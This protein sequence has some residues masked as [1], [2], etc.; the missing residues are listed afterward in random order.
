MLFSQDLPRPVRTLP[1]LLLQL[2]AHFS[3]DIRELTE[4]KYLWDRP[5]RLSNQ[6]L[7]RALGT[8]PHTPLDKA[9]RQT[10]IAMRVAGQ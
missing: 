6:G 1:W 7:L 8:E 4:L 10:L 5:V 3:R 9:V 2:A